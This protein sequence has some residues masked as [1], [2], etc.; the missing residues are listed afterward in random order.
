MNG[1]SFTKPDPAGQLDWAL[2]PYD[3]HGLTQVGRTLSLRANGGRVRMCAFL[4][5]D[6]DLVVRVVGHR[7]AVITRG[8]SLESRLQVGEAVLVLKSDAEGCVIE[9]HTDSAHWERLTYRWRD[10]DT[11][12]VASQA[13]RD[14]EAAARAAKR[15][16]RRRKSDCPSFARP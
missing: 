12:G 10:G 11:H 7:Q 13:V 14:E 2:P 15:E 3:G 5:R 4:N 1:A 6:R 8:S 16:L 9:F